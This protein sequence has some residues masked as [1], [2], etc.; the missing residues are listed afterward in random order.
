M[1]QLENPTMMSDE[2]KVIKDAQ[3]TFRS[4]DELKALRE[5][6]VYWV[7]KKSATTSMRSSPERKAEMKWDLD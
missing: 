2:M 5:I 6:A 7:Q 3:D 1:A 4:Y